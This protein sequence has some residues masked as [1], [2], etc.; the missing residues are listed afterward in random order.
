[1]AGLLPVPAVLQHRALHL[2]LGS[3]QC[4]SQPLQAQPAQCRQHR[5]SVIARVAA[6]AV[7]PPSQTFQAVQSE[8]QFFASLSTAVSTGKA[9][10]KLLNGFKILY[11]NYKSAP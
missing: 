7:E 10:E 1:M 11:T 6:Q 9:P 2:D 3:A 8:A 5:P 4:T